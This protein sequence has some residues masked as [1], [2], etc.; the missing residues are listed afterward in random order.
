MPEPP[1]VTSATFP[2][3]RF[4]KL[5]GVLRGWNAVRSSAAGF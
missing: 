4:I 2:S 5:L 3:S 1:P